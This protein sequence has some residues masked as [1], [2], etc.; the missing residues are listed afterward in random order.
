MTVYHH[1]YT[2]QMTVSRRATTA[3]SAEQVRT[4]NRTDTRAH[5]LSIGLTAS[6]ET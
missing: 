6:F 5:L 2:T 4:A 1:V 3:C